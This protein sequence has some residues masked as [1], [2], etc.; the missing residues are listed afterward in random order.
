MMS[1]TTQYIYII[2]SRTDTVLG[3]MIRKSLGGAV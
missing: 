3:R 1:G 2:V